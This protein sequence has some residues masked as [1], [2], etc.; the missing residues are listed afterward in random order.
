MKSLNCSKCSTLYRLARWVES[1]LMRW[2]HT[3]CPHAPPPTSEELALIRTEQLEAKRNT[4]A[5]IK[6]GLAADQ[7]AHDK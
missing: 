3:G 7:A 5:D 4:P 6:A 1:D 2:V